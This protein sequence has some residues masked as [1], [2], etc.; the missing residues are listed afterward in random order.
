MGDFNGDL[1]NTL[2]EKSAREPNKRGLK[3]LELA[4]YF[5]LCPVNLSGLCGGPI[6]IFNSHCG[7]HRSTLV[8]IFEPVCSV[9]YALLKRLI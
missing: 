9:K 4:D 5:N 2:G 1:G 8:Y 3:L 7:R 6:D